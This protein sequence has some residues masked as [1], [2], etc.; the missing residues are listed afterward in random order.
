MKRGAEMRAQWNRTDFLRNQ[1]RK[2]ATFAPRARN[3][4]PSKPLQRPM[5]VPPHEQRRDDVRLEMRQRMSAS[6]IW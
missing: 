2:F 4:G 6:R 5:Y 3:A 1:D